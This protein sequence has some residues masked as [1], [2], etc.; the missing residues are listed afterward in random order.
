MNK[1]YIFIL[2]FFVIF[3]LTFTLETIC[4]FSNSNGGV[5]L[6]GIDEDKG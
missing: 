6:L 5:L 3:R 4:A 1:M 2:N